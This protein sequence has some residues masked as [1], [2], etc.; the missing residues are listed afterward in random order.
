MLG[1]VRASKSSSTSS[2]CAHGRDGVAADLGDAGQDP[3]A[4]LDGAG[5]EPAQLEALLDG[6]RERRVGGEPPEGDVL[7]L[8]DQAEQL[9]RVGVLAGPCRV[10]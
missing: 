7:E 10:A 9:D 6:R 2:Y 5:G 1:W 3:V 4:A 8:G